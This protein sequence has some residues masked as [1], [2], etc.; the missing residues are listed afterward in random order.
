MYKYLSFL[1]CLLLS[2]GSTTSYA[3]Q[4]AGVS[5]VKLSTG[6]RL[7]IWRHQGNN[8]VAGKPGERYAVEI[9]NKTGA[10]I[11][12]VVSVDGVNVLTGATAA[13]T[14]SGY[15]LG[16]WQ[17]VEVKGWRKNMDEVAA[18]YFTEVPDSY[19]ARTG[20]AG[21]VG[22]IGVA[23]FKEYIEPLTINRTEAE[24]YAPAPVA[25]ASMEPPSPTAEAAPVQSN[26]LAKSKAD[27]TEKRAEAKLGTGH[28][29]R[30][31]SSVRNTEFQRAAQHPDEIIS[32][33]YASY[34]SLVA[35]GI[36]PRERKPEPAPN[37]FPGS[38]VP[39]PS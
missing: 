23:L 18:F 10:R 1:L 30:V 17:A 34:A 26:S 8:Y 32:I 15:V 31:N 14:Q 19:A 13:P 4:L 11:L 38:F 12:S 25:P 37:P 27:M 24:R 33:Q 7:P 36:I 29:E 5:I 16:A 6:E 2:L 9:S 21:N 35:R 28:G 39:D 22:V 20:R 3:G